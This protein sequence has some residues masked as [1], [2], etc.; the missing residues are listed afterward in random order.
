MD[1]V[2]FLGAVLLDTIAAT[3]ISTEDELEAFAVPP[4][5]PPPLLGAFALVLDIS[6]LDEALETNWKRSRY[7]RRPRRRCLVRLRWSWTFLC[8]M[9]H[10][11]RI[12]SV[13]GTSG[14]PAAVAWCVCA[15]LGHF[16][17]G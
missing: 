13:R 12:G 9:R 16:F 4:A 10:W 6:L 3:S 7:L 15:G 2:D 5:A 1:K 11:R 17:V 8:W 14:G